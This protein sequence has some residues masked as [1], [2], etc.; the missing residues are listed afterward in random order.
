VG[1]RSGRRT[2]PT[3]LK[4]IVRVHGDRGSPGLVIV[5]AVTENII[6]STRFY[7]FQ[8]IRSSIC[9]QRRKQRDFRFEALIFT[10]D[11]GHAISGPLRDYCRGITIGA[12]AAAEQHRDMALTTV[13]CVIQYTRYI[14]C[15]V[16][17]ALYVQ[18]VVYPKCFRVLQ[19]LNVTGPRSSPLRKP[20]QP[21]VPAPPNHLVVLC[22]FCFTGKV[23]L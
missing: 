2:L 7:A 17:T 15:P 20:A 1:H 11:T 12:V 5:S 9:I 6:Q 16:S 19:N 18:R 3:P 23:L 10:K 8:C 13:G 14:Q 21:S 4:S 22:P